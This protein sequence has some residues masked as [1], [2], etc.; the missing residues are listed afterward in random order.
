[1]AKIDSATQREWARIGASQRLQ[2]LRKEEAEIVAIFP[3]LGRGRPAAK[4]ASRPAKK[5]RYSKRRTIS[6]EARKRM[7]E[8]M[9]KYWARRKAAAKAGR[10][11]GAAKS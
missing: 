9:R 6:P 1:L 11:R 8:G 2:E 7:A 3:E 4:P 10:K 5:S